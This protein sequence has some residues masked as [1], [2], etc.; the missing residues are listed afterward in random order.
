MRRREF[1]ASLAGAS[2][3]PFGA[4]AQQRKVPLLAMVHPF[5]PVEVMSRTASLSESNRAFLDE[6]AR[7]GYVE[8]ETIRIDRWTAA[9]K[10]ERFAALAQEGG[11]S[12]PDGV[13]LLWGR[14]PPQLKAGGS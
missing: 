8:G 13:P 5:Q 1:L 3:L 2:T 7:L 14:L 10:P 12:P 4:A 11:Q 9:G 6:L